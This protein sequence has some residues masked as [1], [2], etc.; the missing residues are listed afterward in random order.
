M[1]CMC[2]YIYI[3]NSSHTYEYTRV[4]TKGPNT[5][6]GIQARRPLPVTLQPH[7]FFPLGDH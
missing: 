4:K 3:Q 2:I 6:D 7:P 5:K 1:L